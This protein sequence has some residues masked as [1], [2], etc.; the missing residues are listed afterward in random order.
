MGEFILYDIEE[1]GI[2][3]TRCD[4]IDFTCNLDAIQPESELIQQR[5]LIHKNSVI[6]LL[7]KS[8]LY[9]DQP[10]QCTDIMSKRVIPYSSQ[11]LIREEIRHIHDPRVYV[12]LLEDCFRCGIDLTQSYTALVE[13]C[14]HQIRHLVTACQLHVGEQELE[15]KEIEL[16]DC[17]EG[18]RELR[19]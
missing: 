9:A 6:R 10:Q 2:V 18:R 16:K 8:V 15:E 11:D 17:N 7:K 12:R 1:E 3:K 13:M 14:V 5:D 19:E 4:R